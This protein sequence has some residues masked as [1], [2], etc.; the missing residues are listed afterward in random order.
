MKYMGQALI[1]VAFTT[2]AIAL[3]ACNTQ[4]SSSNPSALDLTG[5][6]S[7]TGSYPN[8]PF[9]LRLTQSGSSLRGS[10]SD[11]H[12]TSSSVTGSRDGS[13]ITVSIDF[14]DAKLNVEGT[15]DDGRHVR[16]TMRTSALGNTPYPFAMTR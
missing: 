12:D 2:A 7:G 14:G 4:T 13:A 6:W 5:T 10:Y 3:A 16:G 15:I 1:R 8:A 11:R 9:E